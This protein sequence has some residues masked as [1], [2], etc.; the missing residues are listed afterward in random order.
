MLATPR[1]RLAWLNLTHDKR[2]LL[3]S[4]LGIAFAVLL[5]FMQI[6]F[7]NALLDGNVELIR[8]FNAEVVIRSKS[9]YVLSVKD[10]FPRQRL[11]QAQ[12][13]AGVEAAY[14][15]YLED[16]RSLWKTPEDQTAPR[17]IRVI[18]FDPDQ[19]VL[20]IPEVLEQA[21]RLREPDTALIDEESKKEYSPTREGIARELASRSIRVVGTFRLGIDFVNDGNI[22]MSASNFSKFFPEAAGANVLEQVEVGLVKLQA[23]ADP[24]A[25]K[26]ALSAALPDDVEVLTREE[27]LKEERSFWLEHAPIG[28]VFGLGTAIGFVVGM[29]I[30]Y[31]I[32]STDVA[33][34]LSE[35]ATLKAIGYHN[36]SLSFVVLEE[37]LWL[38]LFG[39]MPGLAGSWLLYD[40]LQRQTGLPMRLTGERI[41]FILV[42]TMV[43]CVVSGVLTL[44][45]VQS[46][47][48][49]EV[50]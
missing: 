40:V 5:M 46:A 50:F 47:D 7:L 9:K 28:F 23:G 45:K 41:L 8:L 48:P 39:F 38:S 20:R 36:R 19:P 17:H 10:S 32:L 24:K 29:V 6:G 30:C 42:L 34:H 15:L 33:D 25:L 1:V 31:Q 44:R 35:Y 21:S 3:V 13:V 43:M 27:Y 22:I 26:A 16:R 2:R 18:A 4:V 12:G 49:A 14:P 11:Y 37:G